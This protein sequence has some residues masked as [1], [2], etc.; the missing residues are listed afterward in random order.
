MIDILLATYNGEKYLAEQIDSILKQSYT[1]WRLIVHDDGSSDSTA[2]IIQSYRDRYPDKILFVDDKVRRLGSINNFLHLMGFASAPYVMF[3]D[4][5]DVWLEH[6]IQSSLEALL[7]LERS[8]SGEVPL[9]VFTDA[10]V[11][12]EDLEV[13]QPSLWQGARLD[14]YSASS[15]SRLVIQNVGQ[16]ATF[17]FNKA[18]CDGVKPGSDHGILMHDWWFMLY[19]CAFGQIAFVTEPT[20]LYRQHMGNVIGAASFS[21]LQGLKKIFLNYEVIKNEISLTQR[22][23]LAFH[24]RY[25]SLLGA[26]QTAFLKGYGGLKECNCV[27]RKLFVLR[28]GMWRTPVSRAVAFALLV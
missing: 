10:M 27:R 9:L 2:E 16:G 23:A 18:L 17:L 1:C 3:C 14:P 6:K 15:L 4:Q 21:L 19:A 24:A 7:E 11:V 12:A 22:Q 28:H 13:L 5:D 8:H 25:R 26:E 20:M